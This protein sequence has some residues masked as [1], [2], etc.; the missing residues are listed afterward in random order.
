MS[1]KTKQPFLAKIGPDH[2]IPSYIAD[3]VDAEI[4]DLNFRLQAMITSRDLWRRKAQEFGTTAEGV[5]DGK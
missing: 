2:F 1:V 3:E 5:S 4:A